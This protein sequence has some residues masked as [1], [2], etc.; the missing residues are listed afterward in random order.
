MHLNC[1]YVVVLSR[2]VLPCLRILFTFVYGSKLIRWTCHALIICVLALYKSVRVLVLV[3]ELNQFLPIMEISMK[4]LLLYQ[5]YVFFYWK[6]QRYVLLN[7]SRMNSL[8]LKIVFTCS[9]ILYL[10][11]VKSLC[12]SITL[13]G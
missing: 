5:R 3:G 11:F 9:G 4:L 12:S 13:D 6:Y 2:T 8:L 7:N 10:W 1:I